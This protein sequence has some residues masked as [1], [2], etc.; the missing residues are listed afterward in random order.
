MGD[1]SNQ[2]NKSHESDQRLHST[3]AFADRHQSGKNG[4]HF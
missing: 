4:K 3:S 1:K 2:E